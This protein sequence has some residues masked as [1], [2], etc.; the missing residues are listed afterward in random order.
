MNSLI[1]LA[2]TSAGDLGALTKLE[3]IITG[4]AKGVGAVILLYG[5][6]KFALAFQ[7]LDQQG[8]HQAVFSIVAGA[9]LIAAGTILSVLKV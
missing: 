3:G 4:I 9:V 5:I 2:D 1:M 7:K 6:I 8:E